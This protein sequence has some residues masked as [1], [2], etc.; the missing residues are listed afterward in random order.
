M[1][2]EP[3]EKLADLANAEI[4]ESSGLARS[5]RTPGL[6]WTHNDSGGT[7]KLFALDA[8]GKD[9]G[10]CEISNLEPTDWEDM[11]SFSTDR[12]SYL[13]I[14]DVGDNQRLRQDYRIDLIPEPAALPCT[15]AA[16]SISFR[17]PDGSHDCESVGYDASRREFIL[18]EKRLAF[19]CRVYRIPFP[20]GA[21]PPRVTAELIAEVPI[22]LATGLDISPDG[23]NLVVTTYGPGYLYRRGERE[24]WSSAFK[25]K[26]GLV[27]LPARHQGE[28]ICFGDD[29]KTLYLTSEKAPA[30]LWILRPR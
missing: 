28:S 26:A 21:Q 10:V 15:V 13:F 29:G 6:L 27:T 22:P 24:D 5:I 11:G 16:K 23:R 4:V 30:P 1:T 19:R 3:A 9:R 20:E 2:Y 7:A 8:A 18:I 17:Y 12:N 25:R 14:A